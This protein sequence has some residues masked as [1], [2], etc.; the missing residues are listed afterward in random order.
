M[1]RNSTFPLN[2]VEGVSR[3]HEVWREVPLW[4]LWPI[5]LRV[6]SKVWV[7][8][9]MI[10]QFPQNALTLSQEGR[11]FC[12]KTIFYLERNSFQ[13]R[14]T[15]HFPNAQGAPGGR[16]TEGGGKGARLEE[17]LGK[18]SLRAKNRR[19]IV[20][21]TTSGTL[22]RRDNARASAPFRRRTSDISRKIDFR[23]NLWIRTR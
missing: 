10:A 13:L 12:A 6:E 1:R 3:S 14:E 7:F 2:N 11:N 21:R 15:D 20:R 9:Q 18:T 4:K 23:T 22:G 17:A 5:S 19:A 16:P 8:R